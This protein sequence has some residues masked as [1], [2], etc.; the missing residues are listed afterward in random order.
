MLVWDRD[1]GVEE[2][3]RDRRGGV[4]GGGRGVGVDGGGRGGGGGRKIWEDGEIIIEEFETFSVSMDFCEFEK[5]QNHYK[6]NWENTTC[7][8]GWSIFS[9]LTLKNQRKF[10]VKCRPH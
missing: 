8:W 5:F 6:M 1:F 9:R 2:M 7:K 4:G 3:G 10:C